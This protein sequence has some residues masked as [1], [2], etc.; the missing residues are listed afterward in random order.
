MVADPGADKP[1]PI[2]KKKKDSDP[3]SIDM[4]KRGPDLTFEKKPEL[5]L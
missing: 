4:K 3:D 1:D 5:T 2:F